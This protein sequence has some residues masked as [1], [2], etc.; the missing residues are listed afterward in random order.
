MRVWDHIFATAS[1]APL[2][3]SCLAL[4]E[5]RVS[6]VLAS[7]E[8]GEAIELLQGLGESMRPDAVDAFVGRVEG[9]LGGELAPECLVKETARERGRH[10]RPSDAGLPPSILAVPPV[11][12]VDELTVG[13]ISELGEVVGARAMARLDADAAAAAR[14]SAAA[15]AGAGAGIDVDG[16]WELTDGPQQMGV[17]WAAGDTSGGVSGFVAGAGEDHSEGLLAELA[18][19]QCM[20]SE[21]PIS[22][23]AGSPVT[24][25]T[26]AGTFGLNDGYSIFHGGGG[27]GGGTPLG[28]GA[29]DP[30]PLTSGVDIRRL[31]ASG[32]GA[33]FDG[34]ASGGRPLNVG[35]GFGATQPISRRGSGEGERLGQ[36]VTGTGLSASD[37]VTVSEKILALDRRLRSLPAP[38]VH[39]AEFTRTVK[40][41]AMRP[42]SAVHSSRLDA[43]R[44]GFGR[45]ESEF[46]LLMQRALALGGKGLSWK[47][48]GGVAI[49]GLPQGGPLWNAWADSLFEH[50]I[51][52]ADGLLETLEVNP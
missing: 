2:F 30:N 29:H 4:L 46:R 12:E 8:M 27:G 51:T 18:A 36:S 25:T 19:V 10:R 40:M 15:G 39:R 23:E 47:T 9:Y 41:V 34:E 22:G 21:S 50:V 49:S 7:S 33:S 32:G 42:L 52:R 37:V 16:D 5:P 1:R 43:L 20:S 44:G 31:H 11:T 38:A 14:W 3:A 45:D 28:T 17:G 35:R 48:G 13:L 26:R 6:D 24:S